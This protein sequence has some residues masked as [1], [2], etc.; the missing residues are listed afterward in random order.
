MTPSKMRAKTEELY[1][2]CAEQLD[3]FDLIIQ[4]IMTWL[5]QHPE[6]LDTEI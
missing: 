6:K 3:D 5:R 1:R 2:I 4:P